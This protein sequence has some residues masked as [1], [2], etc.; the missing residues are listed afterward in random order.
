[1]MKHSQEDPALA[2]IERLIMEFRRRVRY[3]SLLGAMLVDF[4]TFASLVT[5]NVEAGKAILTSLIFALIYLVVT[6][7]YNHKTRIN[8]VNMVEHLNRNYA[9]LEESLQ[10]V[11]AK[12]ESLLKEIQ[13]QK[14][15]DKLIQLEK[16]GELNRLL[17]KI[18]TKR[19]I[20]WSLSIIALII[21]FWL[22]MKLI[23]QSSFGEIDIN[24]VNQSSDALVVLN[25]SRLT[26]SSPDYTGLSPITQ[27]DLN[28]K[29]LEGAMI[30][31]EVGTTK[32][33]ESLYWLGVDGKPQK[34]TYMEN[35]RFGFQHEV[36]G[37]G[38]YRLAYFENKRLVYIGDIYTIQAIKDRAPKIKILTPKTTLTEIR[39]KA[40]K[41]FNLKVLINDDFAISNTVIEVSVAKGSGEAV[42]FRDK[43]FKFSQA[44]DTEKG[45][46]FTRKWKLAELEMEPGDEAYFHI[47]AWDNRT[48]ESQLSKSS[49]LILRWL[50]ENDE[51]T[52]AEG[53]QIRFI[54]E[55]FRSQRQIIIET[56]QL[57]ADRNDLESIEF[58]EKSHDLGYSQ[59]D[60]KEKYGQFLGDEFGEGEGAMHG[61]ADGYH[62]GEDVSQGEATAGLAQMEHSDE[63]RHEEQH[64]EQD[65]ASIAESHQAEHMHDSEYHLED[66]SGAS[67]IIA[68]YTHE[69]GSV[70]VAPLSKSDPKTWM[71][72]AVHEMWQAEM[73]LLLSEPEKA[74]PF[75]YKAYDYLKRARQAER[76]YVKRLGFEPPPVSED[77]RLSGELDAIL[78]YS[79]N[80]SAV[81][82]SNN[83][84]ALLQKG[85]SALDSIPIDRPLFSEQRSNLQN[86]RELLLELSEN[87]PVLINYAVI[88]EK[89][90]AANQLQLENCSDCLARL[91]QKLWQI[92]A[93]PVALPR[94]RYRTGIIPE[95]DFNEFKQFVE[96]FDPEKNGN[97]QHD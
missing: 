75:E 33:I 62:G 86:L 64:E 31:W 32:Y 92:K 89:I 70:E 2:I 93:L 61:L 19:S 96:S 1:M 74:L 27:S 53:I 46:L 91:K 60:L 48:P 84:E 7:Y 23:Q 12:P 24:E 55:F 87:R 88:L 83:Q 63:E 18:S 68:Q 97:K 77:R 6:L 90:L 43:V 56:E 22:I 94:N 44:E 58:E 45:T 15:T 80:Q 69:H 54:P 95:Q 28:V 14:V 29:V 59:K 35:G 81:I 13:R 66:L 71:K 78:S 20:S 16:S 42:K 52:L 10:L 41:D 3:Q 76:I 51:E 11:L 65:K 47:K 49:S 4:A 39:E 25:F 57:I 21:S 5:I 8:R 85:F 17:P 50:E 40:P 9:E 26:V 72:K 34:M 30:E 38:F 73:H 82:M 37:S 36:K 79:L 67:D